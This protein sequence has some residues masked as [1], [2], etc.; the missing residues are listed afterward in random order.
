MRCI[1]TQKAL[2]LN[3]VHTEERETDRR[4][5][6]DRERGRDRQKQRER[7]RGRKEEGEMHAWNKYS[8]K[9]NEQQG[10]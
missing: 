1:P 7:E 3:L 4:T 9:E 8:C 2:H 6:T 5:K 10:R